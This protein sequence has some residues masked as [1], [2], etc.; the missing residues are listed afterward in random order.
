MRISVE[1]N[2]DEKILKYYFDESGGV[3][4]DAILKKSRET[5][6]TKCGFPD[7]TSYEQIKQGG[8]GRQFIQ[9]IE[10][11]IKI[12]LPPRVKEQIQNDP[13]YRFLDRFPDLQ[14]DRV[15]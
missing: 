8:I 4:V 3:N 12:L 1:M 9:L 10:V 13:H 7:I 2:G 11:G 14:D 5:G 15:R 6:I